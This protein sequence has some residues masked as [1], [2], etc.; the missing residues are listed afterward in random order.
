MDDG[1]MTTTTS[2]SESAKTT[3]TRR[4]RFAL[5]L[6]VVIA[7]AARLAFPGGLSVEHFDE[8]VYS[9]NLW[10]TVEKGFSYP[11]RHLYAPPL[12]PTA[13]EWSL[14]LAGVRPITPLLIG[15]AAGLATIVLI[16]RAGREWFGPS[17][18][19]VAA[20]LAACSDLHVLL[21]RSALTDS[22]LTALL[23]AAVWTGHR[24]MRSG[25]R[26][27]LVV[28]GVL[29]GLAWWTKYNG[30]LPLAILGAGSALEAILRFAESSRAPT[31]IRSGDARDGRDTI[32]ARKELAPRETRD[33]RDSRELRN[34]RDSR[35]SRHGETNTQ[36]AHCPPFATLAIRWLAIAAVAVAVWSPVWWQLRSQ[37]GYSKVAANHRKYVVGL[38]G[39]PESAVT[40]FRNNRA[41]EGWLT[42]F[43]GPLVAG[44][45]LILSDER[46]RVGGLSSTRIG[47]GGIVVLTVANAALTS[48][49]AILLAAAETARAACRTILSQQ[50]RSGP[51]PGTD[52]TA[53]SKPAATQSAGRSR[54]QAWLELWTERR[55][56]ICLLAA[57]FFGL[58][59]ATPCYHP[60]ARLTL[61]W[62]ACGW[63][64]IGLAFEVQIRTGASR[65]SE[66]PNIRARGLRSAWWL[67]IYAAVV[68]LDLS[69]R[70]ASGPAWRSRAELGAAARELGRVTL[71]EAVKRN[72]ER[73]ETEP[74]IWVYAEPAVFYQLQADGLM[75][76]APAA[77][78]E[79]AAR[80]DTPEATPS[81]RVYL[82]VGPHA[83]AE[84]DFDERWK[85]HSQRF[86]RVAEAE[87]HP[88]A[89]LALDRHP[90]R[91]DASQHGGAEL[92]TDVEKLELYLLRE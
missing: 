79:Q 82:I 57:W 70:G 37:G 4:E 48:F 5:T 64:I 2:A 61:P 59:V 77:D 51:D 24:G 50:R 54:S 90:G 91:L 29:T 9:S 33:N 52:S 26:V 22:P 43:V 80:P 7:A 6:I 8:G 41:I 88:S 45:T 23:I 36:L 15:L 58:L 31:S 28:A 53:D 63:L 17:A 83:R 75:L 56:E 68:V 40:Q 74:I 73:A 20:A 38:T 27:M 18:G 46:R 44:G 13:I 12:V 10:F 65:S 87:Y 81:H 47:L 76:A 39:W 14:I 19:L 92:G 1:T 85:K 3:T 25:H 21:S 84:V 67:A 89:L 11:A 35:D 55:A 34:A 42:M 72:P 71:V 86:T 32:D 69:W 78:L 60:Y 49:G 16:W 30:W 66:I 62:L